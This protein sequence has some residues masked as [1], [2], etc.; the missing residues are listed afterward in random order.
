M[1]KENC[2][3]RLLLLSAVL[4]GGACLLWA[5]VTA[6]I[7]GTVTDSSGAVV[8]GAN[9]TL[10]NRDTGLVRTTTTDST[11]SYEFL[12]IPVGQNYV[13]EVSHPGFRAAAESAITLLVNQ[14]FRSDFHLQVEGVTQT[15]DVSAAP[16][17]V[18][19]T[20]TQLGDVIGSMKMTELPLNGRNYTDLMGLQA[21]VVPV[22]SGQATGDF[23]FGGN[24]SVNGAR[25]DANAFFINGAPVEE[26]WGNSAAV[27]PTLDSIQEFRVL[28]NS[29]DAEYG[30]FA[31]S[32]VNV[33]TKSGTNGFHGNLYEFL[34][35]TDL[36]ARN[37]FDATRGIFR[38]NQFGGTF[39]GRI[40]KDRLFFFGDYQGTRQSQGISSGNQ[41]VPSVMERAG[42]FSDVGTTGYAP[43]T[44]IVRGSDVPGSGSMNEVLSARLGYAVANGEP[45]WVSGC[46]TLADAQAG[47][48]VFP[49]A[50]IPQ[51]A[52]SPAAKGMLKYIPTP[53]GNVSGEPVILS[54]SAYAQT[55]RDDKWASRI[56][57]NTQHSGDWSFYYSFDDSAQINPFPVADVP[58]FPT[59]TT[60]RNQLAVIHNT[61]SFRSSAVN[62]AAFS[63]FRV[64]TITNK[65][66]ESLTGGF[67]ALGFDTGELGLHPGNPQYVYVPLIS[68]GQLG[69]T[70]GLAFLPVKQPQN[71]WSIYDN[72]TKILGKHTLKFGGVFSYDQFNATYNS[73]INGAFDFYGAETGNDFA[74]FLLGAPDYFVQAVQTY[75]Y[76][77]T[78]YGGVFAQDSYR[79]KSDLTI[80]YGLRWEFSVPWYD[81]LGRLDTFVPGE[82]SKKF[83]QAPRGMVFPGDPGIPLS[84][85]P[86]RYDNFA[87]RL[88]IAYS[89]SASGGILGR[90]TGGPGKTSIRIGGGI[91]YT[92]YGAVGTNMISGEQPWG[93]YLAAT[94]PIYLEEPYKSR[95]GPPDRTNPIPYT[96]PP[97]SGSPTYSFAG[98]TPITTAPGYWIHNRLPY[99]EDYNFSVQRQIGTSMILTAAYVGTQGHRLQSFEEYNPGIASRCLQI[100]A[101]FI[102]AGEAGSGC[103]PFGED[104]IYQLNGQT[105]YGTR[106][107][108]VTDGKYLSLGQLDFGES[109]W[110]KDFA[111]SNY[112]ALQVTLEKRVGAWTFLGA[113]TYSKALDNGSGLFEYVNP[114]NPKLNYA[115]SAFDMRHN[116]VFSYNY[117][118]PFQH[119]AASSNGPLKKLLDGWQ[120]SGT[121]R[122]TTGFPITLNESGDLSLCGCDVLGSA[123]VDF[124]N[125]TGAPIQISDP[126]SSANHQYFSRVPFFAE[127]LG[128]GGNAK[129]RFF[130]GPGINNWDVALH[131]TTR[132]TERTSLEFRAEFFNVF[133]HAQFNNPVGDFSSPDFGD[134][135]SARDPRIG[136]MALKLSF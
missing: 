80:N 48:C 29:F 84:M 24:L 17:Q 32:V 15:V 130:S 31:G 44:G 7:Q 66:L 10:K 83:P 45:Y 117:N 64:G 21:G 135:T 5:A 93:L 120:I 105:F 26:A 8:P 40:I 28:T 38:Q 115:L 91:F 33:V 68:L 87:P 123:S 106:P 74:D 124:P 76:A 127:Q 102:A 57:L 12:E 126:R 41:P 22:P 110:I 70:T 99:A 25:E 46:N 103:G 97:V 82:Q 18:E 4:L 52:W 11:G 37:F 107:Y 72:F 51:K 47:M 96:F 59:A 34:R 19:A 30:H 35:N 129:R 121:T 53:T 92:S 104:T 54:S 67:G 61:H 100:R 60:S 95:V 128:V 116:F 6:R 136:Q 119:L 49:G 27:A 86:T 98:L 125:Y 78:K 65:P 90:L 108:S 133:N 131:K 56:D 79:L 94:K 109:E 112:N 81:Y 39:G 3:I 13:V 42:D 132:I 134:V 71:H 114:F 73:G 85:A 23:G 75:D 101:L 2:S 62:E 9:V 122:F 16:V 55:I 118:L 1:I 88:G 113:Y 50:A 36:D 20:S 14:V 58:G 77:R 63:F 43:L 89:P 111:N 69:V